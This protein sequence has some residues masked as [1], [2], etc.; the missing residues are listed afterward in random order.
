MIA[1]PLDETCSIFSTVL[2][3]QPLMQM[4]SLVLSSMNVNCR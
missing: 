1:I 4:Q 3:Q 2:L